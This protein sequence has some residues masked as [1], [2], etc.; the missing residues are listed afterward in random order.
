MSSAAAAIR[1][2]VAVALVLAAGSASAQRGGAATPGAPSSRQDSGIR[3]A[4]A[5]A[6]DSPIG[7][8]D[9]N[10][11]LNG[12]KGRYQNTEAALEAG[13]RTVEIFAKIYG[14]DVVLENAVWVDPRID[15]TEDVVNEALGN[16]VDRGRL[17]AISRYP[18]RLGFLDIAALK[19]S[20]ANFQPGGPKDPRLLAIL[21]DTVT[22]VARD[23][24]LLIVFQDA[25]WASKNIDLTPEVI[26][27][28][29]PRLR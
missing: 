29:Q 14:L 3:A 17:E 5:S 25:V 12:L 24:K 23:R 15:I 8:I 6:A 9:R 26:R 21:N 7:Y 19:T 16:P 1:L 28:M 18:V 13:G 11:L 4:G 20:I 22:E 27:R 2:I 10:R